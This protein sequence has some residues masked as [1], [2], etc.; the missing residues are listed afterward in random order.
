M[1]RTLVLATLLIATSAF[2]NDIDPFGFEKEHF[3]FSKARAEVKGDLK[4]AQAMGEL[5]VY[6]E[7][8]VKP[9][10]EVAST[11]TRAQIA[12]ETR[13]AA[14]LGLLSSY[15]EQGLKQATAAQEEQI[16]LAGLSAVAETTAS[17]K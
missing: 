16:K 13:E 17:A 5:P 11:K 1:K 4:E 6:G 12:A 3:Q 2:A 7:I 8:G 14:R 9:V 10:I 15:G